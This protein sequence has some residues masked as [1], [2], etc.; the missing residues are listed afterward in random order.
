MLERIL[1]FSLRARW[2]VIAAHRVGRGARRVEPGT[3]A[4]R[5]RA[6]HHQRPGA[7][8]HRGAG[9]LAA[10]GRAAHHLPGR[11]RD[12]R[13]AAPRVHALDLPL[14]TLAGDR[15]LRGRHRHLLRA[16]A[17]QRARPGSAREA[18]AGRR[19][20]DWARSRPGSARSSCSPSKPSR[21]PAPRRPAPGRRP[22]CARSRT[23]SSS[24][25]SAPCRASSRSTRSAAS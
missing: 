24:R 21:S 7:D 12:G 3:P 22:T 14:R 23:G 4:D 11:D 18:A 15:R 6:R 17:G 5:R 25:S 10:R 2:V 8:Q 13:A 9:H 19:A 16:P 1:R 20:G